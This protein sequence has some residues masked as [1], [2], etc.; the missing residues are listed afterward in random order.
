MMQQTALKTPRKVAL[1]VVEFKY[2]S[3]TPHGNNTKDT[4]GRRRH[5]MM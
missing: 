3:I 1:A 4:V 2:P 5:G